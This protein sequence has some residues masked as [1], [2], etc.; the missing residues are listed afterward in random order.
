MDHLYFLEQKTNLN[1]MKKYVEMK[2]FVKLLCPKDAK[3]L[4]YKK[5]KNLINHHFL[6][7]QIPTIDSFF[8]EGLR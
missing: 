5:N 8:L 6:F 2:I 3:T 1:H 7:N 4:E